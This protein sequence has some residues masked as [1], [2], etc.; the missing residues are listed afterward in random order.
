MKRFDSVKRLDGILKSCFHCIPIAV[1]SAE[2]KAFGFG[3][4][5]GFMHIFMQV[6]WIQI[7]HIEV[8]S[9][10]A[11]HFHDGNVRM[12]LL[13][14]H[15]KLNGCALPSLKQSNDFFFSMCVFVFFTG[16]GIPTSWSSGKLCAWHLQPFV[17][18]NRVCLLTMN[19][20]HRWWCKS[21]AEPTE[22]RRVTH[23][24]PSLLPP[25]LPALPRGWRKALTPTNQNPTK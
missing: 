1:S 11:L 6:T 24:L 22:T 25:L 18:G 4:R 15:V 5:N 21:A 7:K 17:G 12:F 8:T 19:A 16:A 9:V 2:R 23:Q 3:L 14:A 10:C 13:L 20:L